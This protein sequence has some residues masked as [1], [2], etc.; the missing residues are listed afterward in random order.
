MHIENFLLIAR[1]SWSFLLNNLKVIRFLDNSFP[2]KI[3]LIAMMHLSE[4]KGLGKVGT[5]EEF[6]GMNIGTK[7]KPKM[8]SIGSSFSNEERTRAKGLLFEYQDVVF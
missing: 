2:L 5:F 8:V 7:Y 6:E 1:K 4:G 3:C